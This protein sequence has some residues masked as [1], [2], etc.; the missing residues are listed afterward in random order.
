MSAVS[1]VDLARYVAGIGAREDL[2]GSCVVARLAIVA[3]PGCDGLRIVKARSGVQPGVVIPDVLPQRIE[4]DLD[5][6]CEGAAATIRLLELVLEL[7]EG[8]VIRR[9]VVRIGDRETQA[10]VLLRGEGWDGVDVGGV[11]HA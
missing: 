11:G 8:V 7:A 6:R 4:L 1:T 2:H 3:E 5:A 9:Q 10:L